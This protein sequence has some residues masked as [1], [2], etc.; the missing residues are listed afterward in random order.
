MTQNTNIERPEF[1]TYDNGPKAILPFKE[2]EYDNR[3]KVLRSIMEAQDIDT[4]ILTSM[5]NIAYYS[6]FLY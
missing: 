6:G 5:H 3:L 4:V 2:E 1:F